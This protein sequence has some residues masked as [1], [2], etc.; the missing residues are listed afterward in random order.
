MLAWITLCHRSRILVQLPLLLWQTA[1]AS[2][3]F[4]P[5]VSWP[6]AVVVV[7]ACCGRCYHGCKSFRRDLGC[8][9]RFR[10]TAAPVPFAAAMAEP[11]PE[12][13]RSIH[14]PASADL[15]QLRQLSQLTQLQ[16]TYGNY[17]GLPAISASIS[18]KFWR[19]INHLEEYSFSEC[20]DNAEN[21]WNTFELFDSKFAEL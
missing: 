4:V 3:A 17:L 10:E 16:L 19:K 8:A 9:A 14:R 12:K 6:V 21:L 1:F 11:L 18:W 20:E 13:A 5:L 15:S 2:M 7:V